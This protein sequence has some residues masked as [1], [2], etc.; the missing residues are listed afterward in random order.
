MVATSPVLI[1]PNAI[2]LLKLIIMP[3]RGFR[4]QKKGGPKPKQAI[5]KRTAVVD[6]AT[7]GIATGTVRRKRGSLFLGYGP[8]L[9]DI[10]AHE[11]SPTNPPTIDERQAKAEVQSVKAEED[12]LE[13][14]KTASGSAISA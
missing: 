14:E 12:R 11:A 6:A 3:S 8:D 4:V 9:A 13:R 2:D 10:P 5:N 1:R 7:D